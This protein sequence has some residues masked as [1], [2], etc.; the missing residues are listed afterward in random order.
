MSEYVGHPTPILIIDA[1]PD[2]S[3]HAHT[4]FTVTPFYLPPRFPS[5]VCQN[6]IGITCPHRLLS[7]VS[8]MAFVVE[9]LLE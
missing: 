5:P 2:T 9:H 8:Q 4:H 7:Y 3:P 6:E 1:Q